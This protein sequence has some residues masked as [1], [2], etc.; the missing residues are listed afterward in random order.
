M[1]PDAW[2]Y[3]WWYLNENMS[4]YYRVREEQTSDGMPKPYVETLAYMQK[5]VVQDKPGIHWRALLHSQEDVKEMGIKESIYPMQVMDQI[6]KF[7]S[8]DETVFIFADQI[9]S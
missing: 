4:I 6:Q 5:T 3:D 8:D 1:K 2:K 9:E 7:F